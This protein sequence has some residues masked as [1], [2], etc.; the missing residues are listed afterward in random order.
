MKTLFKL[1]HIIIMAAFIITGNSL[2]D[3][4][5]GGVIAVIAYIYAFTFTRS[6]SNDLGYNSILMSLFHWMIRT[7]ISILM[8]IITK[9]IFAI[10]KIMMGTSNENGSELYAVAMCAI[11]WV[12]VAE[13]L[14]S[15]TGLK[16][17]YW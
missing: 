8:I 4:I 2:Y 3:Q 1:T 12:V 9:P 7:I 11:L 6:I 17:N 16:K 10:V 14:K 5:L 15:L 13:I